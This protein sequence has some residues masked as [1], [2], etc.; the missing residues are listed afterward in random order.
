MNF[1][2]CVSVSVVSVM[3]RVL[4]VF[5]MDLP[6]KFDKLLNHSILGR[7]SYYAQEVCGGPSANV[8]LKNISL[9]EK[10]QN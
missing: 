5:C 6:Y 9:Y 2:L 10:K 4:L 8:S 1:F 3:F 7:P